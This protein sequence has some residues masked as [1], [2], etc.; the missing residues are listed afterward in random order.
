MAGTR[1]VL[2]TGYATEVL[3]TFEDQFRAMQHLLDGCDRTRIA[4]GSLLVEGWIEMAKGLSSC[5]LDLLIV[6]PGIASTESLGERYIDGTELGEALAR[7]GHPA[8]GALSAAL[9]RTSVHIRESVALLEQ[10]AR[11]ES[12][13][14]VAEGRLRDGSM[15]VRVF[16]QGGINARTLLFDGP[17]AALVSSENP[18]LTRLERGSFAT[19]IRDPGCYRDLSRWFSGLWDAGHSAAETLADQLGESW[20]LFRPSPYELYLQMLHHF[21]VEHDV[22]L[23]DEVLLRSEAIFAD[24]TEFQRDAVR[25]ALV[26]LERHN[27]CFVSDVVGLGKSFIGAAILKYLH[28]TQA[29]RA[30]IICP[31]PLVDMW[32]AYVEEYDL[33]ARVVSAGLLREGSREAAALS[34]QTDEL[35]HREVVLID[36]SHMFRN[37]GTQKYQLLETFLAAGRKVVMLTATPMNRSPRDLYHQI[38]L[39]HQ[40]D[41]TQLPISPPHLGEFF[42]RVEQGR[43]SLPDLLRHLLIRRTRRDIIRQYGLDAET[44]RRVEPSR[45]AEYL[46]GT[47]RACFDVRGALHSFPRR[48]LRTVGYSIETTYNGF[49]QQIRNRISEAE[50][51]APAN[52][53]TYARYNRLRYVLP[54]HQVSH[55]NLRGTAG[56]LAGLMR[57]LLFKR[58]ESSVFA[59]R[60]TLERM[61]DTNRRLLNAVTARQ[62]EEASEADETVLL[63]DEERDVERLA[64]L[65]H[66]VPLAHMDLVAFEADLA[67]DQV[68]LDALLE[69]VAELGTDEDAKFGR[70]LGLLKEAELDGTKLI[71]FSQYSETARYLYDELRRALPDEA[72]GLCWSGSANRAEMVA[73]FAP[74]SNATARA[75]FQG[76][77]LRVLV[78]TDVLSEGVNLQDAGAVINYDLHWN[79]VRL[80]QR[81]GRVDRIGSTNEVIRAFNFLPEL[82]LERNLGLRER[83]A[84]RIEEIHR[85]I[86]EDAAILD[87]SERLNERAMYAIYDTDADVSLGELELEDEY[88]SSIDVDARTL[89]QG[90]REQ[91]PDRYAEIVARPPGLRACK[92]DGHGPE[93]AVVLLQANEERRLIWSPVG[94][95]PTVASPAKVLSRVAC[96][97]SEPG[98]QLPTWAGDAIEAA[99]SSFQQEILEREGARVLHRL[100]KAQGKVVDRLRDLEEKEHDA[101][102]LNS[103]RY[104]IR[105]FVAPMPAA[106]L[107]ALRVMERREVE[108]G[109]YLSDLSKLCFDHGLRPP[110]DDVSEERTIPR[111]RVLCSMV[112]VAS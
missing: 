2:S 108:T 9:S 106:V 101:E 22:E 71:I 100:P 63:G 4:A 27:G 48:I 96:S 41:R 104:M 12:M 77:E 112:L 97:E 19:V 51:A 78:A 39:F 36:E 75:R 70:L 1:S 64:E 93:G 61:S 54:E 44:G 50:G 6:P 23:A 66:E 56:S 46:D 81:F 72:I 94:G 49:Y 37:P 53:L 33:G 55:A 89:L 5:Q 73:R 65:E 8:P 15:R 34:L 25:H 79:P 95:Q 17:Q 62:W 83:L 43:A 10:S 26:I 11:N 13:I 74:R 59:F 103:V 86:G 7:R 84:H 87:P 32:E 82:E 52:C 91:D 40:T 31:A 21:V 69:L 99:R 68:A 3:I 90:L 16:L 30:V 85:S 38:K 110:T 105:V 14:K 98:L 80:I 47:R 102:V 109:E 29:L 18:L 42:R 28:R 67:R 57:T 24:L 107:R 88:E 60:K 111:V 92:S 20:A 76:S 45:L 58:L 35:R